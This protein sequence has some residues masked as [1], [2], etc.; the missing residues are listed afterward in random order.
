M[1]AAPI[2]LGTRGSD[3]ALWQAQT[4]SD[5]LS[6]EAPM[7]EVEITTVKTLGDQVKDKP[8]GKLGRTAVFTHELD[9]ALQQSEVDIAVH[10]LKDVETQL[11]EGLVIAAVL[12]RGPVED[13]LVAA[14][15]LADLASGARVGTGSV[16]RVAQLQRLRPDLKIEGIRGNVP[17]RLEKLDLGEYD[18]LIMARAGLVRL[19]YA[20]RISQV[21]AADAFLP[22]VG[23]GAIAIMCREDDE[24]S[25]RLL[26][27][28]NHLRTRQV[29]DAERALL[30]EVG[31]GCNV[32]LG[33]C[34]H[35]E[36]E[37]VRMRAMLFA[38]PGEAPAEAAMTFKS[39]DDPQVRGAQLAAALLVSGGSE[40]LANFIRERDA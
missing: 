28:L 36:G 32:P 38:E 33:V 30:K 19:G 9:G 5:L 17:T 31:G 11:A 21:F 23:Q 6:R 20:H 2:R 13:A 14:I 29:V 7:R 1:N 37:E 16:R 12:P 18:A 24:T 26:K 35:H 15:P 4:V 39:T 34:A 10:S 8:I 27:G 3:L 22:A 40:I 25:R